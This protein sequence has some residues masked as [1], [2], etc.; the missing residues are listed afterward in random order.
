MIQI[1][2]QFLRNN[3]YIDLFCGIGGFH[4]ALDSFGAKCVFAS[5]INN[6]AC[7]VYEKNFGIKPA[8][9]I[10]KI[11]VEDIPKHDILCAGFPC[12]P[13]SISGNQ[14]GFKDPR[15]RLF[16]NVKDI[17]KYHKPKL[18]ILENVKNL[19]KHDNGKTLLCV[20]NELN[21]IGYTV[22][23][24]VLNATDYGIPQARK[25]IYIVAFHKDLNVNTFSFPD[26]ESNFSVLQ[27]ILVDNELNYQVVI[28]RNDIQIKQDIIQERSKKIIRIGSLGKGRQ[29]ERIYSPLGQ[30]IT[31]SS[32][33]GGIGGK[34]GMYYINGVVRKLFPRE[35][36]RLMGFPDSFIHAESVEMCYT[37]F[38]N[39]VVI[40]VLQK[41]ILQI[42]GLI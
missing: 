10:T 28:N 18:I 19:E 25:R 36:A 15:G 17:A 41:I 23:S 40:D 7:K 42:N 11:N 12:Q 4:Y 22:F 1:D 20:K 3:T 35:C 2:N 8:G 27:D 31:L 34:C 38:G 9:D 21:E 6:A 5:D 24:K 14:N 13:F 29:G 37:Q 32:Q 39:S 26:P 30:A 33:T 16:F